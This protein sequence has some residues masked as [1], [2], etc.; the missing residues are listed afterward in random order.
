MGWMDG[1]QCG[2]VRSPSLGCTGVEQMQTTCYEC[3]K[4]SDCDA[5][6]G[7]RERD[8]K[9]GMDGMVRLT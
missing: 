7:Q 5:M 8:G 9:D 3:S 4:Q 2:W 6:D 1:M